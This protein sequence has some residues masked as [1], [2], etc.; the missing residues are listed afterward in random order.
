MRRCCHLEYIV[1]PHY[2]VTRIAK[3]IVHAI[4]R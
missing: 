3:D 2:L 1:A 4:E